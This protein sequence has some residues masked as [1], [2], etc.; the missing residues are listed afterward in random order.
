MD[1]LIIKKPWTD[2]IVDGYKDWEIRRTK[3]SK[4]G[5]RIYILE[6]K[7]HLVV[8][9]AE[10]LSCIHIDNPFFYRSNYNHHRYDDFSYNDF[11]PY[12]NTYAWVLTNIKKYNIP[13]H[14]KIKHGA[15]IWVKD[16]EVID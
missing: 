6:S 14:Y 12:K 16:V 5:E 8:G 2:L 10:I 9:E 1:G 4:V 7:T 3:T 13:K 11:L 15:Q